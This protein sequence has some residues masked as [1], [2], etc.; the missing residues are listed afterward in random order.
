MCPMLLP[1]RPGFAHR[2]NR[3]GTF[4]SICRVCY[5][6]VVDHVRETE[7]ERA[8]QE[9]VCERAVLEHLQSFRERGPIG[10]HRNQ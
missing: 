1:T 7:L 2:P 6:T 8:E 9:H 5:R 10:L 3:D 4:D